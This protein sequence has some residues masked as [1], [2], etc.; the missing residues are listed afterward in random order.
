MGVLLPTPTKSAYHNRHYFRPWR[1][2]SDYFFSHRWTGVR[3]VDV[4]ENIHTFITA[5]IPNQAHAD[6][7]RSRL[8]PAECDEAAFSCCIDGFLVCAN[9][10]GESRFVDLVFDRA[11]LE[12]PPIVQGTA[13]LEGGTVRY[14]LFVAAKGSMILRPQGRLTKAS[15]DSERLRIVSETGKCGG[16]MQN[17]DR[18]SQRASAISPSASLL[19]A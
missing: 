15:G 2:I 5:I 14:R 11:M 9:L 3:S 13:L 16:S 8:I 12:E 10:S 1:A 18:V 6:T 19:A 4:G 17:T 7:A